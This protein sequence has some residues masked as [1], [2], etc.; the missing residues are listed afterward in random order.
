MNTMRTF[1]IKCR[2]IKPLEIRV[3]DITKA[4]DIGTMCLKDCAYT[5]QNVHDHPTISYNKHYLAA[6]EAI[7]DISLPGLNETCR[8]ISKKVNIGSI[9]RLV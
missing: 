3:R 2:G 7:S 8:L 6:F 1:V 9:T 4:K 5:V